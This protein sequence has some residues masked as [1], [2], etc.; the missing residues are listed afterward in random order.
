MIFNKYLALWNLVPDGEP[1]IT[2]TSQLL[3]VR[4]KNKPA[5][6][7]ISI[8]EEEKQGNHLM[9]WWDGNGAA[10][11]LA[12]AD[13]ALLMERAM[14]KQSLIKMALQDGKDDEATQIICSVI[15][16]LHSHNNQPLPKLV[17]LEKWFEELGL[18][19]IKYGGILQKSFA[20]ASEL[21]AKP[22][23]VVVLHGDIHHANIL[24]FK[25]R[26]WLAI[27]P[28]GLI[29]ERGFDY[30]NIFRNPY[31]DWQ[32][33]TAPGRLARR[34][35]VISKTANLDRTRLLKWVLAFAGLSAA[36]IIEE[37]TEERTL[38][39]AVAGLAAVELGI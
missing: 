28:K 12:H 19:A 1:I 39:L 11:I 7:K 21:L 38:S 6:L 5:F 22:Q 27:D 34:A 37:G 13:N 14:G 3:P 15:E 23:D 24:D 10:R 30:A 2:G 18:A 36:W 8:E 9:V 32:L 25:E 4:Y 33:V 16:K 35:D 20:T 29:G 31:T 17:P 26:G